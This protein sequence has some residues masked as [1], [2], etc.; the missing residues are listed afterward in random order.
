MHNEP[1]EREIDNTP[2]PGERHVVSTREGCFLA[3]DS[4]GPLWTSHLPNACAWSTKKSADQY[5][6]RSY[7]PAEIDR[8]GICALDVSTW[9]TR[10]ARVIT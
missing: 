5:I 6:A 10:P 4:L 1:E 9:A 7:A 2:E 8:L 3:I